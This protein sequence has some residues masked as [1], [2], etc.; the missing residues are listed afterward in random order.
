MRVRRAGLSRP[1]G[2]GP[3]GAG[4]A[5]FT[6]IEIAIVTA[7]IAILA[8]AILP[9]AR[10]TMQRERELELRRDL[11]EMRTAIDKFKDAF[12]QQKIAPADLPADADG[13][14]PTLQTLVD[15]V[16]AANDTTGKRLKF[17]RRVPV[18]PTTKSTEWGMRS[19]R[20][21]AT[22]TSWGGQNV[23]DVFSTNEGRALDGTKYSDW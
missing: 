4:E 8:S 1:A 23:F 7:I 6:F 20:D 17:L 12:D 22:S 15:G 14:P 16:G 10:V 9:L 5:G 11:R 13:Y 2:A 18:D 21:Q 3:A 19:S